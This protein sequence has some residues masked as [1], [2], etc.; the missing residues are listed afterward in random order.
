MARPA[1]PRTPSSP[2]DNWVP[3]T[4]VDDP[5][6][7]SPYEEPDAHWLYKVVNGV[8][9][10]TRTDGRRVSRY[11]YK[12]KKVG[13]LQQSL[14]FMAEEGQ[15]ELALVNALRKDVGRWRGVGYRG[16]SA[17]TKELFAYWFD[18]CRARRLFFCQRE[19]IETIVYLLEMAIP[20]RVRSAGYPNTKFEVD[21]GTIA[22]LL[23]GDRSAFA[24]ASDEI[25][26]RLV[27]APAASTDPADPALI[28]L[29]RLGCKMATGSGKTVV[30]AMIVAWAFC[31][32]GRNPASA[33]FPNAVLICA[34]NLTVRKRL[35][36]LRPDQHPN[37]Y[38]EFELVPAKYRDLL[39]MGKVLV[40]NWHAF[41]PTK[42]PAYGVV[43]RGKETNEAFAKNRLGDLSDRLPILVLNDE[44]HHCWRPNPGPAADPL[45]EQ[46]PEQKHALEEDREEARVW[47]DGL[48]RINNC[49]LLGA[50]TPGILATVDL[51]ATPFYLAQS[52]YPSGSPFPWL[53]S[54]FSL[55][56]AIESGIVRIPRLPVM[57]DKG[58][59]DE[60]GRPDP[61][62]FRLW[63]HI[64]DSLGPKD[65]VGKRWK[66]ESILAQP[67]RPPHSDR[68][69]VGPLRGDRAVEQGRARRA[70]GDDHHLREHR[71]LRACV[72]AHRGERQVEAF[73]E[74]GKKVTQ[75]VYGGG[76]G[77]SRERRAHPAHGPHRQQAPLQDRGRGRREQGR[78]GTSLARHHQH[79]RQARPAR[80]AGPLRRLRLHAHRGLGR[81]QRDQHPGHPRL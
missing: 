62:Y 8:S 36:V 7:C 75:T 17:V 28:P 80:R 26:P 76:I 73:D 59:K 19:A 34:P 77:R 71:P 24:A 13:T 39:G 43:Q 64:V 30:M 56:D 4:A 41:A 45:D 31:N 1:K 9:T 20:G 67:R 11:F 5:I 35:Q 61:K 49:G 38:D 12:T 18:P 47:L 70:P 74:K 27:D 65:K 55:L 63:R 72:R 78:G 54:D 22:K 81:D 42:D 66:P 46:T 52:G 10:P 21:N 58:Q 60:T 16:A 50:G 3:T 15:D 14:E 79:R 29:R 6:L 32:R 68:P 23:A 44:G 33:H 48:D 69:V 2:P 37:Y 57:D 40:T 51:S 53:V 25:W